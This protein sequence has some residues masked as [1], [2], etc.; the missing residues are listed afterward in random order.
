MVRPVVYNYNVSYLTSTKFICWTNLEPSRGGGC[1][2]LLPQRTLCFVFSPVLYQINES[3][4]TRFHF[5]PIKH[6]ENLLGFY[7]MRHASLRQISSAYHIAC[8]PTVHLE[9]NG[10]TFDF[11]SS[12]DFLFIRLFGDCIDT[13]F[14][15]IGSR[16]IRVKRLITV[17]IPV[18]TANVSYFQCCLYYRALRLSCF[19]I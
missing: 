12:E 17:L 14:F 5:C 2:R 4:P 6:V 16:A 8:C 9:A 19:F 11:Q 18:K 15:W 3:F 1:S 7:T 10:L 13:F